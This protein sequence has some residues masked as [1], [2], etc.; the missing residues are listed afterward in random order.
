MTVVGQFEKDPYQG[1]AFRRANKLGRF[2]H[3]RSATL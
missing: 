2:D 1:I 3:A